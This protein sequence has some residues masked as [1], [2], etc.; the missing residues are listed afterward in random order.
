MVKVIAL[1]T[2]TVP[3]EIEVDEKFRHFIEAPGDMQL[4]LEEEC[5]IQDALWN[6]V[7][8]KLPD[9]GYV[10]DLYQINDMD[11]NCIVME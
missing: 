2:T 4:T 5:E 11:H 6:E 9:N 3:I 10:T 8:D 1:V 7:T